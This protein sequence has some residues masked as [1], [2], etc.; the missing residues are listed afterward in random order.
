MWWCNKEN[1]YTENYYAIPAVR[2]NDQN[3]VVADINLDGK[4][5]IV[6]RCGILNGKGEKIVNNGCIQKEVVSGLLSINDDAHTGLKRYIAPIFIG[7][8]NVDSDQYPEIIV[9]G[10]DRVRIYEHDNYTTPTKEWRI[11]NL[12]KFQY[13]TTW[14][15]F[16]FGG[17][18]A[19]G[20]FDNDGKAEI[21]VA[22]RFKY[23]VWKSDGTKL[24]EKSINESGSGF[25]AA[26]LYDFEDDGIAEV[27][28]RDEQFLYVLKGDDGSELFKY[29][30]NSETLTEYPLVADIDG[31]GQA[32]IVVTQ[33]DENNP[34]TN[35]IIAFEATN[36]DWS[37]TRAIWNQYGY[38]I[39]NINEDGRVP[40]IEANNWQLAG[41]NNYR[42]NTWQ[43]TQEKESDK[44]R[45]QIDKPM[46]QRFS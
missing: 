4:P 25:T 26:T 37:T 43:S 11:E 34:S 8:A 28:Y 18:P 2:S 40:K 1:T 13:Y 12:S 46:R 35:G 44:F 33:D 21:G 20:D 19:I 15:I 32:E 10:Y 42:Q 41:L 31:D 14:H 22:T 36:N 7:V 39:T 23:T 45:Y 29:P 5:E 3:I 27:V 6:T 38:H 24:W 30:V 9:T 17:A 16:T